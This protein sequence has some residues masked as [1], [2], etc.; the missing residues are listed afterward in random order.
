VQYAGDCIRESFEHIR[1][2]AVLTKSI[3][4][5]STAFQLFT[6]LALAPLYLP[7]ERAAFAGLAAAALTAAAVLVAWLLL[8]VSLM[9]DE[10]GT[11]VRLNLANK[12]TIIRFLL[13]APLLYLI[14]GDRFTAALVVYIICVATDVID[15][16]VAR[17]RDERTRFGTVMDPLADVFSTGAVFAALLIK[18]FIPLWVFVILMIRYV[19]LFAGTAILFFTKGPL[20]FRATP[21]GKIVGVLQACAVILLVA[22]ALG[23]IE[24]DP[25]AENALFACLGLIFCSVIVSQLVIG[26]RILTKRRARVG[27]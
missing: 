24:M 8:H 22:F 2:H 10:N 23:G 18:D 19:M 9:R 7:R 13:V 11:A 5:F 12:F 14:A 27:S 4:T 1:R 17:W 20:Q 15:G 16:F 6:L 3:I 26:L 25:A 21:V